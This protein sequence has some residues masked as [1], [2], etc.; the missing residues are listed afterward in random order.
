MTMMPYADSSPTPQPPDSQPAGEAATPFL[1]LASFDDFPAGLRSEVVTATLPR[2]TLAAFGLPVSPMRAA[3]PIAAEF[4]VGPN[5][6]VL[7]IRFV[8]DSNR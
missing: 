4:L 1:A 8:D 3:E 2:A 7:A 6:G 5:G